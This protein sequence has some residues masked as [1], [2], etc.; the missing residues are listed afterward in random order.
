LR[1]PRTKK[2]PR[3]LPAGTAIAAQA[4]GMAA[5]AGPPT[6]LAPTSAAAAAIS[7]PAARNPAGRSSAR[8]AST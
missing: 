3:P 6:A 7:S 8:R 4:G 1:S 2:A 5:V